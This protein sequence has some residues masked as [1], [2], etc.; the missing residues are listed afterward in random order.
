MVTYYNLILFMKMKHRLV[1][2]VYKNIQIILFLPS[3][4]H[5]YHLPSSFFVTRSHIVAQL[6]GNYIVQ[7]GSELV[8]NRL[9]QPLELWDYRHVPLYMACLSLS[10][11]FIKWDH[12]SCL[13]KTYIFLFYN[14]Y[15]F[16]RNCK[17]STKSHV[18]FTQFVLVIRATIVEL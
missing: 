6:A 4:S 2:I 14:N 18:P 3:G 10:Y 13:Y 15:R 8:A 12:I 16:T 9:P 11:Y 5:F 7:V 1:F 17:S